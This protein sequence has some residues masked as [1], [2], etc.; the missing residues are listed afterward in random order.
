MIDFLAIPTAALLWR[1]RGTA[2]GWQMTG[3]F[4]VTMAAVCI[5]HGIRPI[6][7][8]AYAIWIWLGERPGWGAPIGQVTGVSDPNREPEWYQ[9]W[10]GGYLWQHPWQALAARGFL[11]GG[12]GAIALPVAVWL[13]TRLPEPPSPASWAGAW[14][15]F[16]FGGLFMALLIVVLNVIS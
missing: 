1:L 15:E 12:I 13:G 4:A 16:Y 9:L 8:A 5:A 14:W 7:A 10:F 6:Y 11:V 2:Y 3:V